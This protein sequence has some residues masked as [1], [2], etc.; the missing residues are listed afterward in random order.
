[1]PCTLWQRYGWT[2][3]L[4]KAALRDRL[5]RGGYLLSRDHWAVLD[6]LLKRGNGYIIPEAVL[7]A[8]RGWGWTEEQV[9]ELRKALK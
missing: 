8:A 2:M 9:R 1:M 6:T 5:V 7:E 4:A 3:K